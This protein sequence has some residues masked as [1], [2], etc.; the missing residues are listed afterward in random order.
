MISLGMLDG[1]PFVRVAIGIYGFSAKSG[2]KSVPFVQS[3][4]K[5][6]V[7]GP[8]KCRGSTEQVY[9]GRWFLMI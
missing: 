9:S 4:N 2:K 7:S 8:W 6:L 1:F 3:M 5:N